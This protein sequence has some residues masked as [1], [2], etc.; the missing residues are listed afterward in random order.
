MK[1]SPPS[2]PIRRCGISRSGRQGRFD[3]ARAQ[4]H[5]PDVDGHLM[6]MTTESSSASHE[7]PM[8]GP[9]IA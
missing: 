3:S 7:C 4:F 6:V 1:V 9:H 8:P 5:S 2:G